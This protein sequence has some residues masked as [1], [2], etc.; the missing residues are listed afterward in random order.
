MNKGTK[1]IGFPSTS[2][3]EARKSKQLNS[4][5]IVATIEEILGPWK[6]YKALLT[7]SSSTDVV[8][9][10]LNEDEVD[11]L[12]EIVWSGGATPVDTLAGAFTPT[13]TAFICGLSA[14]VLS[15]TSANAIAISAGTFTDMYVEVRVRERGDAPILLDART[16]ADGDTII[17]TFDKNMSDYNLSTLV[18]D[19]YLIEGSGTLEP[20]SAVLGTDPKTIL[21]N[22]SAQVLYYGDDVTFSY[23]PAN[24]IESTDRGLLGVIDDFPII[25]TVPY[26]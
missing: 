10:V 9:R 5:Q 6:V 18:G 8:A 20:T 15:W 17:L 24:P 23:D 26:A 14:K 7:Q 12:G 3:T 16:D 2:D 4:G 21:I 25:N 19:P 1:F 22:F 11:Y 13:L